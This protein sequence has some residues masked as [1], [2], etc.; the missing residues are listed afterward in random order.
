[1]RDYFRIVWRARWLI[2]AC[3]VVAAGL[4]FWRAHTADPSYQATSRLFIGPR[5][6][7]QTDLS[8][9]IEELNFSREF[10][11]SY[12]VLLRS[13]TLAERVVAK[14]H[15]DS[16]GSGLADRIQ[17]RVVPDTRIIEVSVT[18]SSGRRAAVL[19]NTVAETF[20]EMQQEFGGRAA[21]NATVFEKALEPTIPLSP[22]PRR[23]GILGGIL[24]G[25]LGV[26]IAFIR[27]QLDTRVRSREDVER[28]LAPLPVLAE[29]P[30]VPADQAGRVLFLS[31]DPRSRQAEAFRKLRTNVQ[32]LSVDKPV[33]RVL[34]TSPYTG[35]G[36][37][38]VAANLAAAMAAGA[39][40]TLLVDA[41][42][43]RP[44]IDQYFDLKD[45][46]G[47][48]DV[49]MGTASPSQAIARISP[50]LG[51]MPSGPLPPNPAELLAGSRMVSVLDGLA[52]GTDVIVFDTPPA[53]PVTDAAALAS[54]MDGVIV[55]LRAGRVTRDHARDAVQAFE[56][57]GIRVLGIVLNASGGEGSG[58]GGYYGDYYGYGAYK[59]ADVPEVTEPIAVE[60]AGNGH[61]A[62]VSVDLPAAEQ[63]P[64]VADWDR[65]TT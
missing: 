47:L 65:P 45:K 43:R 61:S 1:M 52:S 35:D 14:E 49:L 25:L 20:V 22:R 46:P 6:V 58:R 24:G 2:L 21:T 37:S 26:A 54:R 8:T 34:V 42:L 36:K 44:T 50:Y 3:T 60:A 56:R 12:A 57:V 19:A 31:K 40:K 9:A 4:F 63:Q 29:I 7:E 64:V 28:A 27:F 62:S 18:D 53:L 13:R 39:L 16:S 11:S 33:Y 15:L 48:T 41:D 23:D 17:T 38:T 32:F 59:S 5:A 30:V 10:I 55:V 51:V